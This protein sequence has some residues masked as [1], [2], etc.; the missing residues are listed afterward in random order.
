[1]RM[2][3]KMNKKSTKA[4]LCILRRAVRLNKCPCAYGQTGSLPLRINIQSSTDTDSSDECTYK[5]VHVCKV[6]RV[7][8]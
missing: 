2:K 5:Y 7:P 8:T 4:L 3:M 1:M 6:G